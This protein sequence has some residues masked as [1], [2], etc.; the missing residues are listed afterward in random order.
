MIIEKT[1]L[2]SDLTK[3]K[4]GLQLEKYFNNIATLA[5]NKMI[6]DALANDLLDKTY[7]YG[8]ETGLF[9][10]KQQASYRNRQ[11]SRQ[12]G[13]PRSHLEFLIDIYKRQQKEHEAFLYYIESL[14]R[15]Y[16]NEK[17]YWEYNGNDNCQGYIM[18]VSLKNRS[19]AYITEPDYKVYIGEKIYLIEAKNFFHPP[20]FKVSNLNNYIKVGSFVVFKSG[21]KHYITAV[22]GIRKILEKPQERV[23]EQACIRM[24]KSDLNEFVEKGWFHEVKNA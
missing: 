6:T 18:I 9:S 20:V 14:E 21:D 2:E 19:G 10:K 5:R 24:S 3:F 4:T 22:G 12:N 1:A 15:K 16:P 11:N 8:V 23:F 13:V 7:N 17:I